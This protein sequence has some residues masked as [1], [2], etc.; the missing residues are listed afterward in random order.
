MTKVW[1]AGAV[2]AGDRVHTPGTVAVH[3][4]QIVDVSA[5]AAAGAEDLGPDAIIAP[6]AI[7]LH[8][9]AVEKLAEPRPGVRLP[10]PIAV[11]A[12]DSRLHG[13]GVT[14]G[15]AALS[16][17]G[18]EIG[19]R[20]RDATEA[21]AYELRT[22]IEPRVEHRLHLRVEL[23]DEPSVRLAT[24]LLGYRAAAMVSVM[25]HTPGQGQFLT[26]DSYLDFYRRNYAI[27]DHDLVTR[28]GVKLAAAPHL[29]TRLG[30]LAAAAAEGGIP[31]AWHDPDSA[32]TVERAHA[33]GAAV[34][35]FPTTVEA[36]R[37]ARAAGMAVAMGAPNLLLRRSTSGNLSAVEALAAGALDVLVSDYYPEAMWPAA[38]ASGLPLPAAVALVTSAPARAAGL[39]DRGTIAPGLRA[40][41]VAL[42]PDG[43]VFRTLPSR[44]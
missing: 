11:R 16:L 29:D 4:G 19:M 18:D 32:R 14:T 13:A 37:S 28:I 5:G 35:E 3:D 43:T 34:A 9:D 24:E 7:D 33:H 17:A 12:L 10:F 42:R 6:G 1:T 26:T 23:T 20:E 31:L 41:L 30:R 21:L 38:L 25:N 39:R 44:S 40:D 22:L 8:S 15:Y 36:A 27:S 2:V